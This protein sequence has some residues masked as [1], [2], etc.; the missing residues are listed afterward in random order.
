MGCSNTREDF[1][2]EE[3]IIVNEENKLG[4]SQLKSSDIDTNFHRFSISLR[5]T[6]TQFNAVIREM[7]LTKDDPLNPK[8]VIQDLY[9]EFKNADGSYSTRKLSTLGL[10][11]GKG[12][13]KE[14][15][16]VLFHNYDIKISNTLDIEEVR[17][18]LGDILDISLRILPQYALSTLINESNRLEQLKYNKKLMSVFNTFLGYYEVILIKEEGSELSLEDFIKFF[19]SSDIL[20]LSSATKLRKFAIKEHSRIIVPASL[21]KDYILESQKN[22]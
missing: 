6:Q 11:L 21:V 22:K 7:K 2:R 20:A 13:S 17:V 8:K 12:T 5:L 1:S 10:L 9:K 18:L 3:N 15:A 14:K 4:Y 19:D 16:R